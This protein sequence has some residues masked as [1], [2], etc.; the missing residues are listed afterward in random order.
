[1]I[2][3]K[4]YR[5]P[6]PPRPSPP[7]RCVEETGLGLIRT[8]HLDPAKAEYTV[9]EVDLLF[10]FFLI[11][12]LNFLFCIGVQPMSNVVVSGEQ[13][14]DSAIDTHIY[15]PS[16][17]DLPLIQHSQ[18][19]HKLL[20]RWV[21]RRLQRQ[22][23]RLSFP[24]TRNRHKSQILLLRWKSRTRTRKPCDWDENDCWQSVLHFFFPRENLLIVKKK[25]KTN[26]FSPS[27]PVLQKGGNV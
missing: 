18:V 11:Q 27:N 2:H 8:A 16:H 10:F 14:R 19:P 23:D 6:P 25:T 4:L 12:T 1:M 13:Q 26:P 15:S 21:H 24:L 20:C 3:L 17:P 9:W 5:E 22:K 7:T